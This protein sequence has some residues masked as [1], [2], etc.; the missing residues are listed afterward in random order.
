[1]KSMTGYGRSSNRSSDSTRSPQKKTSKKNPSSVSLDVSIRSVN[2]RFLETRLHVPREY[3]GLE[4][5]LKSIVARHFARGTVD[6]YINRSR[7]DATAEINVNR[8]LAEKWLKGYRELGA[9][10]KLKE[11]PSLE[12]LARV[13]DVFKVEDRAEANDVE[14]KLVKK[15]TE[16]AALACAQERK[17][18]G[19]ALAAEL[20]RLCA[21][22]EKLVDE[23]EA[24]RAEANA[25]LEK[26][27]KDRLQKLGFKG[28]VDD[29]R[30]AQEI[31]MQLDRAE[32]S[33]ELTRLRE[34]LKAYSQLLKTEESQGKKLD[35]YAQELL[36]EVN[37]I[38]S[39]SQ[40]AKLTSLV[41]DAK[42]VVEKIREQVQNVE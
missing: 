9:A 8:K 17:R 39:K 4:S 20:Q 18:E 19:K 33:E 15:L 16:A 31:V 10:L 37:T 23:M 38:G 36:R 29:Q 28:M 14:V 13:P 30:I 11:E 5:E 25:D 42:T 27:Y 12:L 22:L 24:L 26:R 6:V 32:I 1:M 3:V 35:F 41:V 34:H 7:P 40:V 2:G 21:R